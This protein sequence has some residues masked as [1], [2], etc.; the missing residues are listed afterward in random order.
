[1]MYSRAALYGNNKAIVPSQ[2][3]ITDSVTGTLV[4]KLSNETGCL[5][6]ACCVVPFRSEEIVVHWRVVHP[7]DRA[8][9]PYRYGILD[10]HV[11]LILYPIWRISVPKRATPGDAQTSSDITGDGP[12]GGISCLIGRTMWLQI[13]GRGDRT[14]KLSKS[15]DDVLDTLKESNLSGASSKTVMPFGTCACPSSCILISS[16]RFY[17]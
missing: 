8:A 9:Q 5:G 7:D 4:V 2:F 12:Y 14:L 15:N 3:F 13:G 1:M 10:V 11:S 16:D 17:C 6:E